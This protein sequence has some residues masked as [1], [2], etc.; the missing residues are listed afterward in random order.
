MY[1]N[2]NVYNFA[3]SN[4]GKTA[5]MKKN[6]RVTIFSGL[7]LSA[8]LSIGCIPQGFE[9]L[10]SLLTQVSANPNSRTDLCN[11]LL[12]AGGTQAEVDTCLTATSITQAQQ[13][14][15]C[16]LS[17]NLTD[18]QKATLR[19][20]LIAQGVNVEDTCPI[21]R[22]GTGATTP[23]TAPTVVPTGGPTTAP[24]E[25]PTSVPTEVPTTG[26]TVAPT[27]TNAPIIVEPTP[28]AFPTSHSVNDGS[29]G[30]Q[31]NGG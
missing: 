2:L 29:S 23:T 13:E 24:T 21:V 7:L 1:N 20:A 8:V 28:T 26:P 22:T 4:K 31:G 12:S 25:R 27:A 15:L 19:A 16:A 30:A 10:P 9:G 5:S 11:L 3:I 18:A 17:N 6:V 14:R